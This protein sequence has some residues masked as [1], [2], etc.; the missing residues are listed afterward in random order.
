MSTNDYAS[1]LD[2]K[3]RISIPT[4]HDP[5]ELSE[6]LFDFQADIVRWAVRM[7]RACI[8]ADCGLGKT[9]MQLE[10]AQQV[11]GDVLILAP[12]AVADQ[13]RREGEKFGIPVTVCKEAAD[14]RPGINVTNY[15]R[16]DKFDFAKFAGLVSDES[17]I[18]KSLAGKTRTALIER[19]KCMPY[20]LA[21]TATPAPND[22]MELGNHAEFVDAMTRAEMLASFFTHDG[23]DTS[24]WRLRGHARLE[25]WKW[26]AGWAVLM[27]K[28][29]DLGYEDAKFILPKLTISDDVIDVDYRPEGQLF[30]IGSPSLTERRRARKASIGQRVARAAEIVAESPDE[31]WILWCDLN[32]ESKMLAKSIL[33]AVEVTGSDSLEVKESR[34]RAFMDGEIRVL[35]TK[36]SIAG[37]GLNLQHCARMAFVGL[38]DSFEQQY[39]AIRRCW[40][41]G[42]TRP[43]TV[44]VITSSAEG[45]VVENI[46]RKEFQSE[47]I[48]QGMVEAMSTHNREQVHGGKTD[49]GGDYESNTTT[50]D[51]WH[52]VNGDSC[53]EIR[54]IEDDS[55]GFSIFSPPF[56]SLYTY[57]ASERDMG[58]CSGIEE[59]LGHF[60]FLTRELHRVTMPGRL[61]S[62]HCMNMPT[63]KIRDGFIGIR[64][65]RG[66]L[67]RLFE[68]AGWIFHSEVVI[69]KNPVTAMQRTKAL[70]LLH[71]QIVKDSCMS[72]Q[73]IPDYLVTMRKPGVNPEPVSGELTEYAGDNDP[74]FAGKRSIN[75]W[76]NYASPVWMDI[77]PSETLQHRSAR[78][79]DDERH[80]C[81]LQLQVIRRALHLWSKPCDL[82]LSP[83]AGIGSEGFEA[84]KLGRKFIGIELK[85][86]YAALACKNLAAAEFERDQGT[87]FTAQ[88]S[89]D[90]T[91]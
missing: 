72:R 4:G 21:C 85:P 61:L 14:V 62:F 52:L 49:M 89:E 15:E 82:V 38:S 32:D 20:R 83:F 78:E 53:E 55:I 48:Y 37:W 22:I 71:K 34:M 10:W 60:K 39:Q 69:W 80:I 16:I 65:F 17:S 64:D 40:R 57:S 86:S 54:R 8:W 75:I 87:L 77:N 51:G 81:P 47:Q 59:F 66:D 35:V 36:P 41:F 58:N 67:I 73:G 6:H 76:Q 30:E 25:F 3:R 28:P 45:A 7:G 9:L 18:L 46:K 23:G 1:F 68:S 63:S 79:D 27:R 24:K 26:V 43:V 33:D 70:G 13:T 91:A 88:E 44:H 19:S 90:A 74:G 84:I 31:P 56:A 12:L 2:S 11:P 50:G 29:S 5:E 42:Q